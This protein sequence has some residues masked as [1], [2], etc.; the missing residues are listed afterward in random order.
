MAAERNP[1]HTQH[2]LIDQDL[3]DEMIF[4]SVDDSAATADERIAAAAREIVRAVL[5]A[6]P[7]ADVDVPTDDADAMAANSAMP[8]EEA[9]AEPAP[10]DDAAPQEGGGLR[11]ANDVELQALADIADLVIVSTPLEALP[12]AGAAEPESIRGLQDFTSLSSTFDQAFLAPDTGVIALDYEPLAKPDNPGGGKGGGGN[13]GGKGGG[14]PDK[15]G[16]DGGTDGGTDP[17]TGVLDSYT[18]GPDGGYNVQIDFLGTWTEALQSAFIEAAELISSLITTDIS[19]IF[20]NGTLYDDIIITAELA[21]IDGAGGILGQAGPTLIRSDSKLPLAAMMEFDAADAENY[22]DA[23]L[24][25]DIVIHEMLHSVGVGTI[26]NLL[27]KLNGY[28][29]ST[30]TFN[31]DFANLAYDELFSDL[32]QNLS[33]LIPVEG[34]GGSGTAY[35]HWDEAT[36]GNELMTGYINGANYVSAMTVASLEDLGYVTTWD[37][38]A[39]GDT[40]IGTIVI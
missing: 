18:S 39:P 2:L 14:K 16:G 34:D 23:G 24:W 21:T 4:A 31:G 36:F 13:G 27:G 33:D 22:N 9:E 20:H 25:N 35:G 5:E 37:A 40:G 8:V 10:V 15:G 30:P 1:L 3:L 7:Q 32:N 6:S 12:A 11:Y 29:T 19:D 28:G 17:G 26:W 38:S